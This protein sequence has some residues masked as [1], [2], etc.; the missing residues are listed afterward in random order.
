MS[1]RWAVYR[2]PLPVMVPIA[3]MGFDPNFAHANF[4]V[5]VATNGDETQLNCTTVSGSYVALDHTDSNYSAV[6]SLLL[7]AQFADRPVH[8]RI[9]EGSGNCKISYALLDRE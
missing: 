8:I 1:I 5:Y 2:M 4:M 3:K 9:V 6:Y 7:A